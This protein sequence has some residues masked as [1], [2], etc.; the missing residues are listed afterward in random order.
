MDDG[1]AAV[2]MVLELVSH[3]RMRDKP[4]RSLEA[5]RIFLNEKADS[6]YDELRAGRTV[7]VR[8]GLR[9]EVAQ[10]AR[11]MQAQGFSVR[12]LPAE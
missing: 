3:Y 12:M 5:L 2:V 8:R 1:D 4:A 11:S 10:M 7:V 9:A 6:A